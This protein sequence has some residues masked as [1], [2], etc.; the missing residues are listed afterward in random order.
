MTIIKQYIET[1]KP[2]IFPIPKNRIGSIKLRTVPGLDNSKPPRKINSIPRVTIIDG[3]LPYVDK[4]P[5]NRPNI[6]PH[7]NDA[8]KAI[9]DPPVS[10]A[11]RP[12]TNAQ[13][14]K[15]EPVEISISAP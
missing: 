11:T 9:H 1:G 15:R 8:N 2:K 4:K 6:K 14:A 5:L 12:Y 10:I 7:N 3:T 13:T